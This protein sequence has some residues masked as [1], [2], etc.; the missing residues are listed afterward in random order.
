MTGLIESDEADCPDWV[1]CPIEWL[2]AALLYGSGA[3]M[4]VRFRV[5]WTAPRYGGSWPVAGIKAIRP[6]DR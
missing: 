1:N 4:C 5:N 6:T 3:G 2:S